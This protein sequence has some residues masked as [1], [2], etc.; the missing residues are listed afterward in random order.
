VPADSIRPALEKGF[1]P[2]LFGVGLLTHRL[3]LPRDLRTN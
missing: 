3:I 1:D 2:G